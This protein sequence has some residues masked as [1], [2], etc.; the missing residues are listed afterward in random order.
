M[1]V[2]LFGWVIENLMKNAIDAM[3]GKGSIRVSISE[4]DKW[5]EI[6]ITDTGKG[7]LKIAIQTNI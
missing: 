4:K 7:I 5:I 3:K 2:E 6:T 1:N